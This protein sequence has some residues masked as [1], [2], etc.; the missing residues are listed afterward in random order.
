M[1]SMN[2]KIIIL[3][4]FLS[5]FFSMAVK[6]QKYHNPNYRDYHIAVKTNVASA[7]FGNL[8]IA[9][10]VLVNPDFMGKALSLNVPVS[11]NPFTYRNNV[12]LKHIAV[13][14]EL[15]MWLDAPFRDFFVGIHAHYAYYN[16]GGKSGL[17]KSLK[18][19]R[20]Q[21]NLFGMGISGGYKHMIND[22]FGLETALGIGY[23]RMDHDV[24]RCAKCGTRIGTEKHNYLGPTKAAISLVYM[25]N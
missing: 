22:R 5:L 15:R 11:Y 7:F 12:K 6:G 18:E 16:V 1:I 14:P 13:Q 23:A 24:Y 19:R 3:S 10:E 2:I 25:I 9:G 4:C 21:G 17:S 8:N 20:Y